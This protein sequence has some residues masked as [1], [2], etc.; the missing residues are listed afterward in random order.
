[1]QVLLFSANQ[2]STEKKKPTVFHFKP[3]KTLKLVDWR[4]E[5]EM[6]QV[7]LVKITSNIKKSTV[8][9]NIRFSTLGPS[10][11]QAKN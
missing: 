10:N 7:A 6:Q 2:H 3:I 11:I 1:M 4:L 5:E 9:I 8:N